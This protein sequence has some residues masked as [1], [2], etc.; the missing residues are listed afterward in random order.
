M[1]GIVFVTLALNLLV[2]A[3]PGYESAW[4]RIPER[5]RAVVRSIDLW[6][7]GYAQAKRSTMGIMLPAK[8]RESMIW[9]ETYHVVMYADP[10]LEHDWQATFW[11]GDK[12]VGKAITPRARQN[13]REDFAES[14]EKLIQN[15]CLDE[16][17]ERLSRERW[18]RD[19]VFR[20]GEL[21][22]CVA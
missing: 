11:P 14:A 5:H 13:Y 7:R 12:L 18:L 9:H 6:D 2:V 19:R 22:E 3:P 15:G 16:P 21:R 4:L 1:L 17:G 8:V 20:P 10:Q